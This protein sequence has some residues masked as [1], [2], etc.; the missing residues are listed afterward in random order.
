MS[1]IEMHYGEALAWIRE[2]EAFIRENGLVV[3]TWADRNAAG[4]Q[5]KPK[6]V[7]TQ[8]YCCD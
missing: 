3:P 7:C 2:L 1:E 8:M 4:L 6:H 5:P